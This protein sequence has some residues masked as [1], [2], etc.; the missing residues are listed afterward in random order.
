MSPET[1]TLIHTYLFL[2]HVIG[3][4]D[5]EETFTVI[6]DVVMNKYG[7]E[8]FVF[9]LPL[10]TMVIDASDMGHIQRARQWSTN[11]WMPRGLG[12]W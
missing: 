7:K 4:T 11:A 3:E 2:W 9:L 6:E 5:Y 12:G 10:D 1:R 8:L